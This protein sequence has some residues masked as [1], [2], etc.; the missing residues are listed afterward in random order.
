VLALVHVADGRNANR[1]RTPI[2]KLLRAEWVTL[3]HLVETELLRHNT[4]AAGILG[5]FT[6]VGPLEPSAFLT[7]GELAAIETGE[8]FLYAYGRTQYQ[9][10]FRRSPNE[11]AFGFVYHVPLGGDPRPRGFMRAG[12]SVYNNAT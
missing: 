12:P 8:L 2:S 9:D 6:S 11:T 4:P 5:S 7:Q 3:A 10:A 1:T